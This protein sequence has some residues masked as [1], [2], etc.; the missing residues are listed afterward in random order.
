MLFLVSG[1][2][3]EVGALLPPEQVVALI[4]RAVVPSLE[5]WA[6]WE[7]EG[8]V[9]GGIFA[10]E[11]AGVLV[12]EAASSEEVG[13]LLGSLPFWGMVKWHVRP[14]QSVRSTIERERRI[15]EQTRAATGS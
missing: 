1:E 14:L 8:R 9:K 7:E 12:L 3:V 2:W 13:Q 11:R 15:A 4:E 10:G 6:R 5:I